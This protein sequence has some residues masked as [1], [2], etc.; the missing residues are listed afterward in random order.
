LCPEYLTISV[1]LF[2]S[3]GPSLTFT[4]DELELPE[5]GWCR[6]TRIEQIKSITDQ[7]PNSELDKIT[8]SW[9]EWLY[10]GVIIE[11]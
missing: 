9:D 1:F 8:A 3:T 6:I 4:N 5:M 10:Y 7:E 11:T 2:S